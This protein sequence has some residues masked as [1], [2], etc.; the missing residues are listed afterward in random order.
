MTS[1]ASPFQRVLGQ[2]LEDLAGPV[3]RLHTLTAPTR[4]SG[5]A[6]IDVAPGAIQ[7]AICWL[8]GLPKP[9]RDVPVS[10]EFRP[11]G[12]GG[13]HWARRF[14]GRGYASSFSAEQRGGESLLV[15]RFGPF[16]LEFRLRAVS[17]GICWL[18]VGVTCVG[19]RAP[20]WAIPKVRCLESSE[21]ARYRFDIEADIPLIGPLIRYRGWLA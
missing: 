5:L 21:D 8:A 10:V 14:S 6:D 7:A 12:R 15:E 16:R 4:V 13:E 9:G 1:S 11:D 3:R 19:I 18:L 20:V 17:G 2:S